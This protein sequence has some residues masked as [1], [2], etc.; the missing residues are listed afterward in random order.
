MIVFLYIL[1]ILL[2]WL[3]GVTGFSFVNTAAYR[4]QHGRKLLKED[5]TCDSCGQQLKVY[6]AVPVVSYIVLKGR[7][8]Y[9]G[10]LISRRDFVN[11]ILGG[12]TA[13]LIFFRYGDCN[14]LGSTFRLSSPL[15]IVLH[16]DIWKLLS[17]LTLFVFFCILDLIILVD[18]DTSEI[19]NRFVILLLYVAVAAIIFV[20][21]VTLPEH[22]IGAVCISI[23]MYILMLVIPGAFGGGDLKLTAVV[24]LLLGWKLE[25]IGFLL[26]LLFGGIYGLIQIIRGKL[27]KGNHFPFGP[28]LCTGYMIAVV[29]GTD[30]IGLYL[31]LARFLHG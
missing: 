15:D 24:G 12:F 14:I 3:I 27:K 2:V 13:L 9:C 29:W 1:A 8:R 22:L 26:G 23:P 25:I 30:I 16:F 21:G 31:R 5:F 4:F 6:E 10:E 7:C 20:P 11:E 17:I 19:P 18:H 28:F